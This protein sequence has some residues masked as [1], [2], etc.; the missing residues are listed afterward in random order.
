MSEE[1]QASGSHLRIAYPM[2]FVTDMARTVAYYEGRLGF[3]VDYLYGDPPF[4]GMMTRDGASFHF[5]HVDKI[6]MVR[7]DTDLLATVVSAQGVRALFREF[8]EKGASFHQSLKIQPWGS[9]DFI[10]ED[11]DR[12]LICFSSKNDQA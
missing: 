8:E 11:P 10:V 7:T 5:R 3:K 2:I 12:N 4:Y 1:P 6:P 9:T